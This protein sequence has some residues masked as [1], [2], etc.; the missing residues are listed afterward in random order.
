MKS[1]KK[2][3]DSDPFFS[4]VGSPTGSAVRPSACF[5]SLS[6]SLKVPGPPLN[7]LMHNGEHLKDLN[8]THT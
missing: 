6:V 5:V 7:P 1:K 4:E 8:A 3:M 2:N